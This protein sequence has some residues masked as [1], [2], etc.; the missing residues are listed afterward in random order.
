[1]S[2]DFTGKWDEISGRGHSAG[3][4]RVCPDHQLDLFIGFSPVGE[5]EFT[6]E[7]STADFDADEI[8]IFENMVVHLVDDHSIHCLTLRLTDRGLTDLFSII[9]SDLAEASAVAE[10]AGSAIQIFVNRL[11]RWAELLR[12][13]R[14][15]ELS[16]K[17]RLGLLGELSMLVWAIDE[18]G[19]DAPL[20]VRGWRGPDGDT[21]DIGLNNVRIEV[22]AQLSTQ[23]QS[24][25]ISSLDQLDWDGRNLFIAVN[26]FCP[27][28][29]GVSLSSLSLAVSSRLATN[30]HGYMEFQRKL[31]V[32]GYDQEAGYT[33]ET[34]KL[35]GLSIYR[36]AEG[37]PRLVP[38]KVPLGITK[39]RYEIA[40]ETINDFL[41]AHSE[42]EALING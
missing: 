37:F 9:C 12:R 18:C 25:K 42:L 29:E 15:H 8:P 40:S 27:S 28:D 22:K 7:S 35:E 39:V 3:R 14:M 6:L 31:I 21:N 2:S 23:R 32:A 24:L 26:R 4:F 20:A 5:R 36:V 16:F 17:E 33:H 30:N 11:I 19:V 1:M 41:I 13:R 34:F 38:S 10:T